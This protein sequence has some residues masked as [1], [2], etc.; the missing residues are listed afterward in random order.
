MNII[1]RQANAADYAAVFALTTLAFKQENEAKLVD[2]L[3]KNPTAF[4]P[5]LSLVA[6]HDTELIG[7]VLFTRINICDTNE[8]LHPSLALAPISVMPHYQQRGVGKLLIKS[9]IE[10]AKY[11]KFKS[12]IVLG[13]TAYY[14][15]F[16]F[17]AA[18]EWG[19]YPPFDV[20][21]QYFMALELEKGGLD[22]S[23]GTVIYAPEFADL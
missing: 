2:A 13:E 15:K 19:V 5:E 11:L 4:V 12:I 20:P 21:S 14:A 3:R 22:K 10:I 7:H 18:A 9:G 16:G 8:N 23:Q 1:I 17:R 6:F